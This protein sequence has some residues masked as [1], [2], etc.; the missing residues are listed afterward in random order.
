MDYFRLYPFCRF[1]NCKKN[2]CIYDLSNGDIWEIE[3]ENI[4]KLVMAEENMPI[5]RD[6]FFDTLRVNNLGQ[7]YSAPIWIDND[8]DLPIIDINNS[9]WSY[10]LVKELF[11]VFSNCSMQCNFCSPKLNR[12]TGCKTYKSK[13]IMEASEL[14]KTIE[15]LGQYGL[16]HV[17]YIG[18]DPLMYDDYLKTLISY[19]Y[20]NGHIQKIYTNGSLLNDEWLCFLS[21]NSVNLNYEIC[22]DNDERASVYINELERNLLLLQK[23][24]IHTGATFLITGQNEKYVELLSEI[25]EKYHVNLSFDCVISPLKFRSSNYNDYLKI[26]TSFTPCKSRDRFRNLRCNNSCLYGKIAVRISGRVMACPMLDNIALGNIR[27]ERIEEILFSEKYNSIIRLSKDSQEKCSNCSYRYGCKDCRAIE[28]N[29]TNNI[30]SN[31]LCT[32]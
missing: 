22:I 20:S 4:D 26:G 6:A 29:L 9:N 7:Y 32:D 5:Y 11:I 16:T 25:T 18:G 21:E 17:S 31:V 10:S 12:M 23:H 15:R 2:A 27:S 3:V 19:C 24:N 13:E 1:V 30:K 28:Y 8:S 14:I